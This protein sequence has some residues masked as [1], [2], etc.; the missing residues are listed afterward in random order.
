M[1]LVTGATGFLGAELVYQ[2]V[3]TETKVRCIKRE[4]AVI[5]K[6]LIPFTEQIEWLIADIL[7]FS[8][9]EDAFESV[10]HV[11]HCAAM[12]SFDEKL[13]AKMLQVNAEG[14]ANIVNLCNQFAV[15]KLVYVSSVAAL[16]N[17]KKNGLID[18]TCFWEGFEVKDAYAV[19]KYRAEMEVWR[20]IN[21]GL[22]AV[23]V[24]PSVIIGAD[25]GNKGSGA[26]FNLAKKKL[27]YYP[28]GASGFV[29]VKDVA[30]CMRL[31]MQNPVTQERFILNSENVSYQ[32]LFELAAKAFGISAPTK[33]AKPWM[34]SL[35]W[36][37]NTVKNFFWGK[38]GGV[39]KS[40]ANAAGKISRY[41]N[42]KVKTLL[43]YEF[44]PLNQTITQI[45][46][47]S[48]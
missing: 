23:I 27:V 48:S 16:G 8:D 10:T 15:K 17:A 36:R 19:S 37:L 12:V 26:I 30:A 46:K 28:T 21:E 6:K 3:K 11:Y 22:N 29:D 4:N 14:T 39:N 32:N 40:I 1:I 5:P 25:A 43:G 18:E 34:L 47:G 33:P 20:G 38:K 9:L 44:I 7:D 35:A 31:L 41:D 2:L 24:N 13:K 42:R 45:A